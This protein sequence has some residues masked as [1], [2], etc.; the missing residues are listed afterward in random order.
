MAATQSFSEVEQTLVDSVPAA[1]R[2]GVE[3][4]DWWRR[5]DAAD[6]YSHRYPE[7]AVFNRPNDQSYGFFDSAD[8]STGPVRVNGNV[9]EMFYDEPK[10][11]P[12]N[13]DRAIDWM[14]QQVREFILHYFMRIS[15]FRLPEPMPEENIEAA[16]LGLSRFSQCPT[17]APQSETGFGYSQIFKKIRGGAV[18]RFSE[19]EQDRIID[20]RTLSGAGDQELDWVVLRNPIFSFGF[21]LSPL[22]PNG[23]Q[24]KIPARVFNYLVISPDFIVDE[25]N[26]EPGIRG[27]YGFGYAFVNDPEP[28]VFGYGPGQLEP[29]FEQLVWEVHDS[30]Q[31]RVRAAFVAKE[32]QTILNLSIDPMAWAEQFTKA[33]GAEMPSALR[34]FKAV[35][36]RLPF[37]RRTF[38]PVLPAIRLANMMT[39]GLASKR[40]CISKT[41]IIKQALFLHFMQHYQ[42]IVGSLQT[43]RQISDWTAS[44]EHLPDFVVTGKSI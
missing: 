35:Y 30:G 12:E 20:L 14:D 6:N 39:A 33:V 26:P 41:Q 18:E 17:D 24:L 38:D 19:S 42:T 16:P 1:L 8:L 44:Q 29:A 7:T 32:P 9:Q 23:P 11:P 37:A 43:W 3:L 28:S 40:L 4:L 31:I 13:E 21:D 34:P 2:S 15:D 10:S 25:S 27:R 5:A 36:D 22:G